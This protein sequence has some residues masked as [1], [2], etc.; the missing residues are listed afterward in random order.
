M[1]APV[2][3]E[4]R[5]APRD[6]PV[7]EA[8]G[9]HRWYGSQHVLA[10]VTLQGSPGEL[11]ALLGENGSG[12]STLLRILAGLEAQDSGRVV[13]RGAIG[14]CPQESL[15]YPWLTP[16]E[17]LELFACAYGLPPDAARA[18]IDAIVEELGLG[19]HRRRVV[20]QLSGGTRQKLNLGLALLADAPLLLLDE[21]YAGLDQESYARFLS[22]TARLK[23]QRKCV[24]VVTHLLLDQKRFDRVLHLRDGRLDA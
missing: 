14:Y 19:R 15:L 16:D 9:V 21:P 18:R 6:A 20:Q 10:A 1:S 7:F 17:H 23:A 4:A 2:L 11:I 5:A 24:V 13:R 8:E 22:L 12:K 3:L